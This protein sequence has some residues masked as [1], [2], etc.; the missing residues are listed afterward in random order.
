MNLSNAPKIL[1]QDQETRPFQ[2]DKPNYKDDMRRQLIKVTDEVKSQIES[3]SL[4]S[5]VKKQQEIQMELDTIDRAQKREQEEMEKQ[6]IK[7]NI[8]REFLK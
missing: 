1:L 4:A 8:M 2:E 5:K 6:I 7:K 3:N